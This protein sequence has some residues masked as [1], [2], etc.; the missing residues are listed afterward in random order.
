MELDEVA[1]RVVRSYWVLLTV[2][3]VL[4]LT[5]VAL[6]MS[7]REPVAVAQSRLQAGATS[8]DA[9]A[10]EAGASVV[11]SQV[12][13][14]ATSEGLLTEVLL[15][16]KV[17][18]SARKVAKS[19]EV[20]GLGSSTVVELSVKDRDPAVAQRLT[21][22]IATKVVRQ[23]NH[24]NQDAI[25]KQVDEIDERIG[26]LEDKLG[27]LARRAGGAFPDISAA[28]ERER[29]QAE[30]SGLRSNRSDLMTQL[31]SAG[32]ASVVQHAVPAPRRDPTVMMAAIAG[33]A[34]LVGGILIAVLAEMVRPTIPGPRRVARRLGVPILGWADRGPAQLADLGRRVRLA[35]KKEDVGRV[36]L[37]GAPGP[38]P[39]R[40]VSTVA[41][42]VYGDETRPVQAGAAGAGAAGARP[43]RASENGVPDGG[44]PEGGEDAGDGPSLNSDGP[45]GRSGT[46]VVRAGGGTAVMAKKPGE[47]SPS[48]TTQPVAVRRA[49]HV[50]AF[51][52]IDPGADE[53]VG[54]VVV[55]GRVTTVA[56]LETVRDLVAASGWPLLG[57]VG[58]S[59][60]ATTRISARRPAKGRETKE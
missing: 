3:T 15:E 20:T 8:A 1:A 42:A 48:E 46:S 14:F 57:V 33:L 11:V 38:L 21:D 37:V 30:L 25:R 43:G 34:G 27:P 40:L 39:P 54:V 2:M 17:D 13:A 18:R 6:L 19:V 32:T 31:T 41:A 26:D 45:G 35:A 4:P 10:G 55:V 28:N 24:S 36:T 47:V 44:A 56:G 29:V 12:K 9:A 59:R 51:E 52:D 49:C 53:T 60:K 23:I 22:A 58:A 16:Q 50:H 5:L 7:G